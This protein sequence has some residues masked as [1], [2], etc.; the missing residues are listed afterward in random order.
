[1]PNSDMAG[2]WAARLRDLATE[3]GV[4]GA[5]LGVWADGQ[6][7]LAAHG[8]LNAATGVSATPGSLF[9]I[10]SITKLWTATMIMQL[11]G[12]GRL[13]LDTAV[14]DV[15]PGAAVGAPDAAAEITI[16]HLLTHSSGIDGDIFTDTGRGTDC[17]ERYVG[18]LARA[19]RIFPPGAAYSYC[20][21]GFVLLGRIIEV[22]DRRDWDASLRERLTGPLNLA[23]T[24]TLPE[25]AIL[26]RAAVGHRERPRGGPG[27]CPPGLAPRGEPVSVWGLPRSIGPAGNIIA[28]AG[29]LLTFAR[30]HLDGGVAADGTRLLAED[31]VTAMQQLQ[32]PVPLGGRTD[33]IGL[34][35]RLFRWDGRQII[36]HDGN[37]IGQ[38]AFL[39]MDPQQRVAACLLTNSPQPD[40]VMRP[41]FTEIFAE[42]AGVTMPA[43]PGPADGPAGVDLHQHAGR[44]ERT[45]R[46]FDVAVR[47]GRLHLVSS[48]TGDLAALSDEEPEEVVLYPA[49]ATGERFVCRSRDSQPWTALA[50]SHLADG[51]PYLFAGGRV[52]PRAG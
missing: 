51:T 1:M 24:V 41:L 8:T 21:S 20:N 49:D 3:E 46:R 28:A 13:S 30:M 42:H 40:P 14:A 33:A 47:D 10:G 32:L 38:T 23:T 37:T 9:Q 45:S 6:E 36:G 35:W 26:H 12:E 7:W 31:L 4:P 15:L 50:F 44:Y 22:L 48:L 34:A 27:G 39:R 5:V 17:L 11:A 25:E 29:D 16:R 18:E 52:T 19:A 2:H 43:E